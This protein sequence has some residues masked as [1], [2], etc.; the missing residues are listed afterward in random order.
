MPKKVLKIITKRMCTL[1]PN[2]FA[3]YPF[4]FCKITID[5]SLNSNDLFTSGREVEDGEMGPRRQKRWCAGA[6]DNICRSFGEF[7]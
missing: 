6:S 2:Y 4:D 5:K 3:N 1:Y 7:L